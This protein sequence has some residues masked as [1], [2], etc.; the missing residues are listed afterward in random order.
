MSMDLTQ[1]LRYMHTFHS[2]VT[3]ARDFDLISHIK[4]DSAFKS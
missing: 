3:E 2:L 4:L 1:L